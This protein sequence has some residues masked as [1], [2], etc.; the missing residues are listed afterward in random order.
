MLYN[1]TVNQLQEKNAHLVYPWSSFHP[2]FL[3]ASAE[4]EDTQHTIHK[5]ISLET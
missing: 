4:N 2:P 3:L 1:L 5:A